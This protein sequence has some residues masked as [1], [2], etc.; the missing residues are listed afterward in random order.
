LISFS[1]S[2]LVSSSQNRHWHIRKHSLPIPSQPL[3]LSLEDPIPSHSESSIGLLSFIRLGA[4]WGFR[5]QFME[6]SNLV[7]RYHHLERCWGRSSCGRRLRKLSIHLGNQ[8]SFKSEKWEM[9]IVLNGLMRVNAKCSGSK[10]F[11]DLLQA[12][13][14]KQVYLYMFL[15]FIV[16]NRTI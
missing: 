2:L 15:A 12:E 6:R 1:Q 4:D 7:L 11:N 13:D 14:R 10:P 8:D 16:I 3:L 5:E 9:P